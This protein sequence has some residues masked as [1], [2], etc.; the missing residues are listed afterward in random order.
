MHDA[1]W[2]PAWPVF[3]PALAVT[4]G[5]VEPATFFF[6]FGDDP[7]SEDEDGS[8]EDRFDVTLT[9]SGSPELTRSGKFNRAREPRIL[10][11]ARS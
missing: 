11:A 7:L 6:R 1:T 10:Y 2:L 3:N 8:G 5:A 9:G 4:N